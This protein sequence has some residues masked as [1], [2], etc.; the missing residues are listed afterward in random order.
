MEE[1]EIALK[2]IFKILKKR[3]WLIILLPILAAGAAFVVVNYVMVP[4]YTATATMY[5]LNKQSEDNIVNYND[6]QSG[7][8]LTA[9]YRELAL[10]K[11]V[12]SPVAEEYN[13][14]A[15][16]IQGDFQISVD[17][18]NNTRVIEI[19]ATSSDP[20]L[21]ANIANSVG[22]EFSYTVSDI[23]DVSNVSFV[24]MAEAPRAASSPK[25]MKI[26]GAAGAVGLMLAVGIAL[27]I[28]FMN[29]TIRTKED[30]ETYLELSVLATIPKLKK[31]K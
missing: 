25:K 18:A 16:T 13:L 4:M 31:V 10:S 22:Y 9:D 15:D 29:T 12:L 24:D 3:L 28:D 8:L 14:N 21:A 5:V 23:M 30:V 1:R 20:Q 6:L 2:D 26:M 11:R 17:A 27:M 7:T 19:S